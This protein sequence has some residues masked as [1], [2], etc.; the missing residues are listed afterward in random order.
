[1]AIRHLTSPP[2]SRRYLCVICCFLSGLAAPCMGFSARSTSRSTL[3]SS[4]SEMQKLV[5]KGLLV[6]PIPNLYILG[7][8]H[9]GSRSAE[10]VKVV[11]KSLQPSQVIVELPPSRLSAILKS[12]VIIQQY[13][14]EKD[15]S[16]ENYEKNNQTITHITTSKNTSNI[17]Q[18]FGALPS[19]AAAGLSYAGLPGMMVTVFLLWSSLMKQTWSLNASKNAND[20]DDLIRCNEFEAAVA[21]ASIVDARI[22]AADWELEELVQRL[23]SNLTLLDWIQLLWGAFILQAVGMQPPDPLQRKPG[24]SAVVWEERRRNISTARASLQHAQ[25]YTPAVDQ[26]LVHQRNQHFAEL[27]LKTACPEESTTTTKDNSK[28]APTTCQQNP[29]IC[30]VG[31]A[32]LDGISELCQQH[33]SSTLYAENPS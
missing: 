28:D 2:C 24:E 25:N 32:H 23:A 5:S 30:I 18:V 9:I 4:S 13:R 11:V 8:I 19:M 6:Q 29:T 27:C 33:I 12:E 3:L 26:V 1:M 22:I 16:T 7:T 10:D 21:M 15:E 17:F 31:L 20:G 14:D